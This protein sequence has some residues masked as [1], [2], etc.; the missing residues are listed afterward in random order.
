[1]SNVVSLAEWK[2]RKSEEEITRL[3]AELAE[4]I[5]ELEI[6]PEPYFVPQDIN[7]YIMSGSNTHYGMLAKYSPTVEDCLIDLQFISCILNSLGKQAASND[8]DEIVSKL[9][10]KE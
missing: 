6:V 10:T 4:L 1:M 9:N 2:K 7:S 3:E 5:G 8:I